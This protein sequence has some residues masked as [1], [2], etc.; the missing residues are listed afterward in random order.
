[1]LCEE[2]RSCVGG[3]EDLQLPVEQLASLRIQPRTVLVVENL[4]TALALPDLPGTVVIMKLGAAVKLIAQLP[5]LAAAQCLYWGDID[6]YGFEILNRAR[7]V[8]PYLHSI[9]MDT[10]T[11]LDH[12][13]F[14]GIEP[15]QVALVT[16]PFLTDQEQET[17]EGLRS[18]RWGES[19]RLE[20][21]R[22][23]W[24][25]ALARLRAKVTPPQ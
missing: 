23:C 17:F 10:K 20:Q 14:C 13:P 2:S 8:V 12:L 3:L 18:G 16:L 15:T 11:L 4:E 1:M 9:L 19:L 6:T 7:S 22:L 5:W 24:T 25:Y 21:E